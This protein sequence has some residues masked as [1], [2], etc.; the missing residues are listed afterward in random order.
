MVKVT[1]I[2]LH[3]QNDWGS[4]HKGKNYKKIIWN[5]NE[6]AKIESWTWNENNN[7]VKYTKRSK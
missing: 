1:R 2:H 3:F 7:K 4:V 5:N 6:F